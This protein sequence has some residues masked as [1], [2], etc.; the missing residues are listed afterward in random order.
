MKK[1][2]ESI[3]AEMI[4]KGYKKYNQVLKGEAYAYWTTVDKKYQMGVLV[5]DFREMNGT[6]GLQYEVTLLEQNYAMGMSISKDDITVEEFEMLAKYFYELNSVV[7]SEAKLPW[8]EE[9][10]KSL[11]DLQRELRQQV[12]DNQ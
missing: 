10:I 2:F 6:I 11:E 8:W 4:S 5:F 7:V 12:R 1:T 9:Q 3:D